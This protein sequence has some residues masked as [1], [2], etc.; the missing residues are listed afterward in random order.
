MDKIQT[1]G[2]DPLYA[3]AD[4]FRTHHAYVEEPVSTTLPSVED[5]DANIV[6][7]AGV[8]V[9]GAGLHAAAVLEQL[10]VLEISATPAFPTVNGKLHAVA[11][12]AD[13]RVFDCLRPGYVGLWSEYTT[14]YTS[15]VASKE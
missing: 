3:V 15:L 13:A 12:T 11:V 14:D 8:L 7:N 5:V 2:R 10:K 6:A 4:W 1:A 9:C